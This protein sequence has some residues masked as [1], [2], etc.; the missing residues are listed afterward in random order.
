MGREKKKKTQR[1]DLWLPR[2]WGEDGLGVCGQQTQT[3]TFR[4]AK[5]QGPTVQHRELHTSN[6]LRQTMMEKNIYVKKNLYVCM[7]ESC[8]A[9]QKNVAQHSKSA[10][11]SIRTF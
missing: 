8:F 6:L 5:Q 1:T 7:P 11:T 3:I 4:M 10:T 9:V 2:G